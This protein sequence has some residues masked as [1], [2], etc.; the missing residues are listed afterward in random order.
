MK[1][2]GRQPGTLFFF[3]VSVLGPRLRSAK[4]FFVSLNILLTFS[5]AFCDWQ[6]IMLQKL[7]HTLFMALCWNYSCT[8]SFPGYYN[9]WHFLLFFY[10]LIDRTLCHTKCKMC[11]ILPFSEISL[12]GGS[13]ETCETWNRLRDCFFVGERV[14]FVPLRVFSGDLRALCEDLTYISVGRLKTGSW[15]RVRALGFVR[16]ERTPKDVCGEATDARD[17]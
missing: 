1:F 17:L 14:S 9:N 3:F 16:H 13:G 4:S 15:L 2:P 8:F 5:F 6:D 7:S 10:W 12:G 11:H